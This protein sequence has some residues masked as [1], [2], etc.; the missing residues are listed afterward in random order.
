MLTFFN[1]FIQHIWSTISRDS[2]LY[3][4]DIKFV[5]I[6][7][8]IIFYFL[9][10]VVYEAHRRLNINKICKNHHFKH[11]ITLYAILQSIFFHSIENVLKVIIQRSNYMNLVKNNTIEMNFDNLLFEILHLFLIREFNFINMSSID[12]RIYSLRIKLI[13]VYDLNK[14]IRFRKYVNLWYVFDW[15]SFI[16]FIY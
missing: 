1:V 15:C 9:K 11:W 14:E 2:I 10:F 6:I 8:F 4:N 5:K 13:N 16:W 3:F 12:F 7:D